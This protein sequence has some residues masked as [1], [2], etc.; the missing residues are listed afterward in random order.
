MIESETM[1]AAPLI[2]AD[3]GEFRRQSNPPAA[4]GSMTAE[5]IGANPGA[6][7]APVL[8]AAKPD[9]TPEALFSA[10]VRSINK[11]F[12]LGTLEYIENHAHE[13]AEE[14]RLALDRLDLIWSRWIPGADLQPFKRALRTYYNLII[15]A[16][17]IFEGATNGKKTE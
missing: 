8:P 11:R 14:I 5:R 4:G 7:L 16:V 9:E 13:L 6:Q 3:F 17:D 15:R 2:G 1:T 10:A 12:Q